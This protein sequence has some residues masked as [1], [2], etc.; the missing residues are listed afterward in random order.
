MKRDDTATGAQTAERIRDPWFCMPVLFCIA[1]DAVVSLACQPAAYWTNPACASEG[2]STW[3]MLL[4]KGPLF[5]LGAFAVYAIVMAAL[6]LWLRGALQK[7]LGM[8]VLLSHSFGAATW[9]HESLPDRWY[10]WAL[11][12]MLLTEAM[13]FTIYWHVSSV[14]VK[15]P[16]RHDKQT[17]S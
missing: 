8:F 12:A 3:A 15:T 17:E 6:L 9:C 13:V 10:W 7:L 16:T 2:N 5:F 1:M 11:L 14:C 4:A